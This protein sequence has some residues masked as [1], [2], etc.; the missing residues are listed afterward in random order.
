MISIDSKSSKVKMD[1]LKPNPFDEIIEKA[2]V[3]KEAE[4]SLER[5]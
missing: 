4:D 2:I 5:T 1:V 3:A